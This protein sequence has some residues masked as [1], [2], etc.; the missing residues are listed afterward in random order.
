MHQG[1]INGQKL[2]LTSPKALIFAVD[3]HL[4]VVKYSKE[5]L[6]FSLS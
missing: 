1:S 5:F 4:E 6:T 2:Y 3:K